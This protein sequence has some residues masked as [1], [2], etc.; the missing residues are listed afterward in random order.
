MRRNAESKYRVKI[1]QEQHL[2]KRSQK[3]LDTAIK[4]L[5]ISY[6]SYYFV[7]Y[8]LQDVMS[9]LIRAYSGICLIVNGVTDAMHILG[10]SLEGIINAEETNTP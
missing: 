8:R 4:S 1:I 10:K 6:K 2:N 5:G 3:Y 7:S 9:Q